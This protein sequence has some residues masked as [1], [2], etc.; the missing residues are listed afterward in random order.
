MLAAAERLPRQIAPFLA[1]AS[2]LSWSVALWQA[3]PRLLAGPLCTTRQDA[4]SLAGHCPA[5]FVAVSLT[6]AFLASLLAASRVRA[7][8]P[9]L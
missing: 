5:C 8:A 1:L 3:L 2:L 6:L 9:A 7:R 4:F